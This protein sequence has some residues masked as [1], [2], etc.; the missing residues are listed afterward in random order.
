MSALAAELSAI[1]LGD[2]RLNHRA[3]KVLEALGKKPTV[4]IPAACGGWD[5]TK[6]AYRLFDHSEVTLEGVLAPCLSPAPR[7]ACASI[8]GCCASKIPRSSTT[9]PRRASPG[10]GR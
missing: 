4:S 10:S 2:R 6:A 1:D 3:G 7:S 8:P 5:E 9:P